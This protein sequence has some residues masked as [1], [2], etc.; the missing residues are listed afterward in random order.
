[1]RR[2]LKRIVPLRGRSMP[3]TVR[4]SEDLPAPFAPTIA[5]IAP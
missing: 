5:T 1:M 2:S 4:M 3:A